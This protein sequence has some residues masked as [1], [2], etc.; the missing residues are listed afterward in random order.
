[1]ERVYASLERLQAL[2]LELERAK[3]KTAE[4]DVLMKRIR[5]ESDTYKALIDAEKS[6]PRKR[7]DST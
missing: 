6:P 4:Y 5:A 1:M 7:E 3:P 2:W